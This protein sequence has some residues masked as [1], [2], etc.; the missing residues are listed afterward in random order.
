MQR[1]CRRLVP[2][3]S[4]A[5]QVWAPSTQSSRKVGW[6]AQ[7]NL[8]PCWAVCSLLGPQPLPRAWLQAEPHCSAPRCEPLA[9]RLTTQS[10]AC[11]VSVLCFKEEK[12]ENKPKP[13]M[14]KI[15][16]FWLQALRTWHLSCSLLH[17]SQSFLCY[18]TWML[19]FSTWVS[20]P[21]W[22]PF[23]VLAAVMQQW[24]IQLHCTPFKVSFL[25]NMQHFRRVGCYLA[26]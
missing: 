18:G 8:P 26:S 7:H 10:A 23:K 12:K 19:F 1:K 13:I 20:D 15:K 11:L 24:F 4:W 25:L 5:S 6:V 16:P 22:N 3:D 17:V 14:K 9:T 21:L 2:A